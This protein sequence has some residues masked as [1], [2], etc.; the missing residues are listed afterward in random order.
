M[1]S[2][3]PQREFRYSARTCGK[4]FQRLPAADK[5]GMACRAREVGFKGAR[6]IQSCPASPAQGPSSTRRKA[7]RRRGAVCTMSLEAPEV[8]RNPQKSISKTPFTLTVSFQ[9]GAFNLKPRRDWRATRLKELS[10][11]PVPTVDSEVANVGTSMKL[12][13]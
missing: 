1:P 11:G 3:A 10:L 4:R 6:I 5:A 13:R 7:N 2:F 9:P 12:G 8:A